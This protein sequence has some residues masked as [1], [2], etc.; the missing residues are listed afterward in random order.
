MWTGLAL[1]SDARAVAPLRRFLAPAE[2]ALAIGVLT[3]GAWNV[4]WHALRHLD[5]FWG[6]AAFLS[7]LLMIATAGLTLWPERLPGPIRTARPALLIGLLACA[8]LY[9]GAILRLNLA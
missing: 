4:F 2:H 3:G 8:L 5:A 6:Q 1:T 7:G 9:S